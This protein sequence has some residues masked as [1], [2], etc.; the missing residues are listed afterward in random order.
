MIAQHLFFSIFS[1]ISHFCGTID[2]ILFNARKM[3][4]LTRHDLPCGQT[5]IMKR[6]LLIINL[7]LI[8]AMLLCGCSARDAATVRAERN[9]GT[10]LDD[11][12]TT[13]RVLDAAPKKDSSDESKASGQS[14]ASEDSDIGSKDK[15]ETSS[16][17][18]SAKKENHETTDPVKETQ[19]D[20]K[21]EVENL[22]DYFMPAVAE[23]K[24]EGILP[25]GRKITL[26]GNGSYDDCE[27]AMEDVDQ[28]GQMELLFR[29]SGTMLE[30]YIDPELVA[31]TGEYIEPYELGTDMFT[32]VYS[33]DKATDNYV[34]ELFIDHVCSFYDSGHVMVEANDGALLSDKENS[35]QIYDYDP[36]TDSYSYAGFIYEWNKNIAP[37]TAKGSP[38][39]A[40][41][42]KDENQ[43]VYSLE[44]GEKYEPGYI[45][46]DND[47]KQLHSELFGKKQRL[48]WYYL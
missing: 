17:G 24:D 44:Y 13:W 28:D 16:A 33:Y 18:S 45:Y 14:K 27:Y 40:A 1:A 20:K 21:P 37:T 23:F 4:H 39:P 2:R 48:F 36:A 11:S 15:P 35:Y 47:M 41:A 8:P 7:I 9:A 30:V 19:E 34:S 26:Q 25:D 22:E 43:R 31:Q 6:K 32:A 46:D 3:V 38:F 10:I 12:V 5:G 29:Y 42:D